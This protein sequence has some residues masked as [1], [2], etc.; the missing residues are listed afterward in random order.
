L[1]GEESK[2][3]EGRVPAVDL[4]PIDQVGIVVEDMDRAIEYYSAT[5]G[6][7]PFKVNDLEMKEVTYKE[8]LIDCRMK[9][10][11]TRQ[12]NIEIELIQVV[13]GETPYTDFLEE[14]GEGLHHLGIRV[15]DLHE[16][17]AKL[18]REGIQ[19]VFHKYY[20]EINFGFAYLDTDHIGGV[21]LELI[22]KRKLTDK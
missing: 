20:P 22:Q 21:M 7:G 9:V 2:M 12:E 14:K 6:W 17:L 5:F 16:L 1:R 10:A 11:R 8:K 15:D 19:P 4:P 3:A 18:A 13:E